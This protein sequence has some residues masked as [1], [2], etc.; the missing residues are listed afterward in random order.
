MYFS[1]QHYVSH[2]LCISFSPAQIWT[3]TPTASPKADRQL[4]VLLM[5]DSQR[6]GQSEKMELKTTYPTREDLLLSVQEEQAENLTRAAYAALP[7]PVSKWAVPKGLVL[8][9][10]S[11]GSSNRNIQF[12]PLSGHNKVTHQDH[13]SCTSCCTPDWCL[14]IKSVGFGSWNSPT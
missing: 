5:I 10:A 12:F 3:I 4:W 2:Q 8:M 1:H 9:K 14:I 6:C 11:D 13:C 7:G